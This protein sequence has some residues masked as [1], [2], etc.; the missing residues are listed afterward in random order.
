MLS[1]KH[2]S[3]VR[4]ASAFETERKY[5][6][7]QELC[8][9]GTLSEEVARLGRLDADQSRNVIIQVARAIEYLHDNRDVV[10]R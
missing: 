7:V 2:P 5:H 1:L 3:I 8:G 10:H 9:G 4:L 6:I